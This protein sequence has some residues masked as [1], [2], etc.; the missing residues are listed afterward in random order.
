MR[1]LLAVS[2]LFVVVACLIPTDCGSRA[3]SDRVR[4]MASV[5][6]IARALQVYGT[7]ADFDAPNPIGEVLAKAN[8]DRRI[9]QCNG[10]DRPYQLNLPVLRTPLSQLADPTRM[11]ILY[12][13]PA[14]HDGKGGAVAFADGHAEFVYAADLPRVL[15][16][17]GVPEH[18]DIGN[19]Q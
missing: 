12:E 9:Q 7:P 5:S 13:D 4:C 8:F 1:W 17:G 11:V 18:I 6:V 15:K 14:N 19:T 16:E 2:L 10:G 3:R